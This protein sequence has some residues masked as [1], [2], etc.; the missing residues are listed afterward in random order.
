MDIRVDD[1]IQNTVSKFTEDFAD[2]NN[3]YKIRL[4]LDA[5][6]SP[7]VDLDVKQRIKKQLNKELI[8]LIL[9]EEDF[10]EWFKEN[11]F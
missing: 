9:F 7:H 6:E 4:Y 10:D 2:Y 1:G 11:M 3:I 8:R 5:L